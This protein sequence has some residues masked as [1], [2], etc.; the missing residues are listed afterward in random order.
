MIPPQVLGRLGVRPFVA[1]VDRLDRVGVALVARRAGLVP[2]SLRPTIHARWNVPH[3]TLV[4]RTS[5]E[6]SGDDK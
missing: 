4:L 6:Q 3:D 1:L 5:G 2:D